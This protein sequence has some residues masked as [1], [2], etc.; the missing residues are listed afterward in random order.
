MIRVFHNEKVALEFSN[1]DLIASDTLPTW[2]HVWS[3]VDPKQLETDHKLNG[4]STTQGLLIEHYTRS[5]AG[6]LS[7][8]DWIPSL[9][10]PMTVI[11]SSAEKSS[12]LMLERCE[13]AGQSAE[14]ETADPILLEYRHLD[15]SDLGDMESDPVVQKITAL[16]GGHHHGDS[17]EDHPD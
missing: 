5:V 13:P 3:V 1:G 4:S 9:Q 17:D 10:L 16:M 11:Q 12:R 8:I 2:S 15:F 6:R 7:T 14:T